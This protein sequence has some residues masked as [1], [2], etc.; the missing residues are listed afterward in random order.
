M[1]TSVAQISTRVFL[2]EE[3][4]RN[5]EWLDIAAGNTIKIFVAIDA[6]QRWPTPLHRFVHWFLPPCREIRR[7]ERR[8]RSILKPLF[9]KRRAEKAAA[10]QQ[11]ITPERVYDSIEWMEE[12]ADG[13][14]YDETI[15]ELALFL[16]A[17][18]TT[19]DLMTKVI[20]DL[21]E[22]PEL[23]ERLRQEITVNLGKSGWEKL[24]LHELKLMDSVLKESQRTNPALIG[25]FCPGLVPASL[26]HPELTP[27]VLATMRRA[28]TT[29]VQLGDGRIIKEGSI[30][31]VSTKE[32]WD[33][34]VYQEPE[35]YD[36]YRFMKLRQQE[37]FENKALL[38]STSVEHLG[39][40]HGKH[41]CP[42][43]FF[44]GNMLKV[45]LCQMLLKYDWKL[46]DGGFPP[47]KTN[48]NFISLDHRVRIAVRRRKEEIII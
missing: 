34:G 2:G 7:Q 48:A 13:K 8:A 23:I 9:D 22:H 24:A 30:V 33:E 42:G 38:V 31:G 15:L 45:I 14:P 40:G 16:A 26:K 10:L 18:H 32:M 21:C 46:V 39:F 5:V 41:G 29:D 4:S 37:G 36:G 28:A 3:L 44:A 43:R 17:V 6:L 19:S 47:V 1:V 35:K 12:C 20:V 25:M 27:T 11:C